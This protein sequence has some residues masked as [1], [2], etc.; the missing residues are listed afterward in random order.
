M[1]KFLFVTS[2]LFATL[3]LTFR[4]EAQTPVT[5][6]TDRD[7]GAEFVASANL[8]QQDV[9]AEG[10]LFLPPKIDRVRSVIVVVR[11]GNGSLVYDDPEWRLLS[12]TIK[13]GLL[14]I[15]FSTISTPTDYRPARIQGDAGTQVLLLILRR[16]ADESG[17]QELADAP[18]I[19]WGHSAWGGGVSRLAISL[20]QRTVALIRYHSGP[21]IPDMEV[22]RQIPLL[23]LKGGKDTSALPGSEELWKSGR[24][25]GAP[26]ALS[27]DPDADHGSDD[28]LRRANTVMIPW[29]AAVLRQR[30]ALDSKA[31]RVLTDASAWMGNN[32]T[33]EI[34]P[35][36]AFSGLTGNA[37]W[38]PDEASARGWRIVQGSR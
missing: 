20:A 11:W 12:E 1:K 16:L 28:S 30:V 19:F 7:G 31:L 6:T 4:T 38:L 17:H 29:I 33:G 2:I 9:K 21:A 26:W 18:L 27:L 14:R 22:A 32:Q 23:I 8:P 10:R 35:A 24:E 36:A 15:D 34:A 5:G 13:A 3:P 37:S 25:I